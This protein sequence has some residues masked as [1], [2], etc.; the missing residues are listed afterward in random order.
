ML[1]I[2]V[3]IPTSSSKLVLQMHK[4]GVTGISWCPTN[5]TKLLSS[6]FD[7]TAIVIKLY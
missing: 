5:T 1:F 4:K 3:Y 6:S 7:G 2:I